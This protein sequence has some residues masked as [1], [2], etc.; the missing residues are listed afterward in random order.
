[1]CT[2]TEQKSSNSPFFQSDF[3]SEFS[4]VL[5]YSL[6]NIC[7]LWPTAC[8]CCSVTFSCSQQK[9]LLRLLAKGSLQLQGAVVQR[10]SAMNGIQGN[11][12]ISH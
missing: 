11:M 8:I 10:N 9:C 4:L 1:M 12:R 7:I 2:H 6:V 5:A 3:C